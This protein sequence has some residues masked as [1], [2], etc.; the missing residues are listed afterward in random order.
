MYTQCIC[1]NVI[2]CFSVICQEFLSFL[3]DGLH[4][5]LNRC[6]FC[7]VSITENIWKV[8]HFE[9]SISHI[10]IEIAAWNMEGRKEGGG[11][12][13]RFEKKILNNYDSLKTFKW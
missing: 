12:G 7:I 4:E 6:V 10:A 11:G 13:V 3:L 1:G 5:D 8:L 9:K 2:C